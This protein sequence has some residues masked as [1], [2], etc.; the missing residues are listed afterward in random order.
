MLI[1]NGN[2]VYEGYGMFEKLTY[3]S[4]LYYLCFVEYI[5]AYMVDKQG[6][7]NA[8]SDLD[9]EENFRV[10]DDGWEH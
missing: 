10:S 9:G 5:S 2:P 3:F 6:M 4:I 1:V 8:D 7:E